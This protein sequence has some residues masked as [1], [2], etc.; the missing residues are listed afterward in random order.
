MSYRVKVFWKKKP[1]QSFINNKYSRAHQWVF[2]FQVNLIN[3]LH[4]LRQKKIGWV[5]NRN[6]NRSKVLRH[7][8]YLESI[9]L[10]QLVLLLL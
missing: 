7:Y 9:K 6:Q 4:G 3:L 5:G 10:F 8:H 2:T 1:G